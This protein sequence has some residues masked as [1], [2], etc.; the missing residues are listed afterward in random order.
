M[1]DKRVIRAIEVGDSSNIMSI[2]IYI[3]RR[4]GMISRLSSMNMKRTKLNVLLNLNSLQE[5]PKIIIIS[6]SS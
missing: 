5:N 1:E 2:N 4:L 3:N 6:E